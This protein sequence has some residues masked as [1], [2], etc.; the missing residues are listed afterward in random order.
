MLFSSLANC[1]VSWQNTQG[2]SGPGTGPSAYFGAEHRT[3]QYMP[4]RMMYRVVEVTSEE[5]GHGGLEL[6]E[7]GA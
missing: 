1:P 4:C 2:V 3:R 6:L 7:V 5:E